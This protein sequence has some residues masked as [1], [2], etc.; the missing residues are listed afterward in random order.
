MQMPKHIWIL[1]ALL[2]PAVTVAAYIPALQAEF[3]FDDDTLLA[4]NPL[5]RDPGGVWKFW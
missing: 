4:A 2:L 5:M 3:I 1:A